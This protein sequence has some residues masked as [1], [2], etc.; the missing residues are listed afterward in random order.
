MALYDAIL[1]APNEFLA[2]CVAIACQNLACG[3]N[4]GN[5]A[6]EERG[7]IVARKHQRCRNALVKAMQNFCRYLAPHSVVAAYGRVQK[8][9]VATAGHVK[10]AIGLLPECH[11]FH[12][13]CGLTQHAVRLSN[14][15]GLHCAAA[16]GPADQAIMGHQHLRSGVAWR[17]TLTFGKGDQYQVAASGC[18]IQYVLCDIAH[19]KLP[20]GFAG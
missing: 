1:L 16:D 6:R 18:G 20:Y 10:T 11:V 13:A 8:A 3:T 12:V 4:Q 5:F 17:G 14:G 15:A 9:G 19:C 2:R 7:F